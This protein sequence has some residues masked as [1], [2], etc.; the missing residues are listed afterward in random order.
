VAQALYFAA[1]ELLTN[2]ARH[3]DASRVV[4]SVCERAG[5]VVLAVEDDGRGGADAVRGS[6]LTGLRRR[7]E[8]FDGRLE[9]RSPVG[10]PTSVVMSVPRR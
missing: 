10:G 3:A 4:L 8:A 2:V 9:I 1:A 6:G 5:S 7:A